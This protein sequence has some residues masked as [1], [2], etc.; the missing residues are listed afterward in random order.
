MFVGRVRSAAGVQIAE[1]SEKAVKIVRETDDLPS[2][3]AQVLEGTPPRVLRDI[4]PEQATWL[5]P[6]DERRRTF[7]VALNYRSHLAETGNTE[8]E[9]PLFFYKPQS[10]FVT[11]GET[12]VIPKLAR[13]MDYEG[14]VGIV[15]GRR[16][17]EA[18]EVDALA[19]VAGVVAVNDGSARDLLS[20]KTAKGIMRD[21]LLTK[22]IDR[23]SAISPFISIGPEV[24][25]GLDAGTLELATHLNGELVQRGRTGEMIFPIAKLVSHLSRAFALLPG[26]VICT[27]TPSGVGQSRGRFLKEGDRLE[28]AVT[29]LPPLAVSVTCL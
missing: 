6:L 28:V 22:G 8:L 20:L 17:K 9:R 26:D 24:R 10:A 5:P 4:P 23:C 19:A 15:I 1:W 3:L 27:G 11:H 16:V 29:T 13:Q 14:E 25:R 21:W 7:G 2:V 18:S 12:L